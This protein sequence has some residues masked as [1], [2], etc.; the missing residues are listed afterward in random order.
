MHGR[1]DD[2]YDTRQSRSAN[3]RTSQQ[4]Y[5]RRS[6]S[7]S[8]T[9]ANRKAIKQEHAPGSSASHNTK[10]AGNPFFR[11]GAS[12]AS[13]AACAVCLGRHLHNIRTCTSSTTFDG[14]EVK[15]RRSE[16]GRLISIASGYTLC[17]DW[18]RPFGCSSTKHKH[19]CSGC[20]QT[21]HGAQDCPRAQKA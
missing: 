18:Q 7:M 1:D 12:S 4:T 21:D 15:V 11:N 8:P 14:G 16:N 6:R 19:F 2:S 17:S 10:S 3:R 9:P 20:E 13:P 5:R